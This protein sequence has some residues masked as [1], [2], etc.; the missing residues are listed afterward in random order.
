MVETFNLFN[1]QIHKKKNYDWA[2][3]NQTCKMR[4]NPGVHVSAHFGGGEVNSRWITPPA[5]L[6]RINVMQFLDSVN[7]W[8]FGFFIRDCKGHP[9][10]TLKC[11]FAR[12]ISGEYE[13]RT[14]THAYNNTLSLPTKLC[15][16]NVQNHNVNQ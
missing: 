4:R 13:V 7:R 6:M 10:G 12:W 9:T 1:I 14:P 15:L 11:F 5:N 8:E 3:N 16:R 2:I